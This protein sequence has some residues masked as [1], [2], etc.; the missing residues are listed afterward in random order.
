MDDGS[1]P[2]NA[3]SAARR[4]RALCVAFVPETAQL[5]ERGWRELE[6]I[7]ARTLA[8]RPAATRRQLALF[9]RML[10]VVAIVRTGRRLMSLPI[11][12]RWELLDALSKSRLLLVRRG[13]WGL[14]TLVFMGYY[15]RPEAGAEI[16]YRASAAG[17]TARGEMAPAR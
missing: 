10:D 11:R 9:T 13:V 6:A 4:F 2:A 5:D 3:G 16:G 15:A 7:V 8:A 1:A 12:R 14:R 17:W